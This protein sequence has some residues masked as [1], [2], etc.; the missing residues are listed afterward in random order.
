VELPRSVLDAL[1]SYRAALISLIKQEQ[2]ESKP[3]VGKVV[4]AAWRTR[5]RTNAMKS[6]E[7]ALRAM[8]S[9]IERCMYCE[10]SHGCDVEHF[11]PKVPHPAGTFTWPN[12][13]LICAVCN[14]QKNSAFD[15]AILNPTRD[16]PFDH[17]VLSPTTG[18]LVSRVGS[19]RGAATLQVM[20]RLSSDQTLTRGRLNAVKKLRVFLARY[21]ADLSEGNFVAA[22]E[23]RRAVVEEPF[24]AVFASILRASMEPNARA[25][26]PDDLV[27]VLA[28]H[29][30]M[31]GWLDGADEAR[32][33]AA[34]PSIEALARRVR[35]ASSP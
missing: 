22:Y 35:V 23:I 34:Q 10:D 21:D 11:R 29:P 28:R 27:D 18:R 25:V 2:K 13:L 31:H 19:R 15:P 24:S 20:K 16:D 30:E 32:I 14:R 3:D 9:G 6:V 4:E 5:R 7:L 8:A 26:L 1:S 33:A 12:L 17:L